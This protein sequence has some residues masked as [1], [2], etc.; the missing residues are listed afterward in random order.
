M[1]G[2][3]HIKEVGFDLAAVRQAAG[4]TQSEMA[5]RLGLSGA[6]G[7]RTVSQMEARDDWLLSRFLEYVQASGACV[8]L[9]IRVPRP[10]FDAP[11]QRDVQLHMWSN[12]DENPHHD[13]DCHNFPARLYRRGDHE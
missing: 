6:N 2:T 3:I 7:Q 4:L 13:S 8:E 12:E 9:V 1:L 5:R 11:E 10:D